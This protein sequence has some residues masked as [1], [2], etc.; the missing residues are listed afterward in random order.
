[1]EDNGIKRAFLTLYFYKK[2]SSPFFA[3]FITIYHNKNLS[4]K[5][6]FTVIITIPYGNKKLFFS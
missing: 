3:G 1:M 6:Y 2:R 4:K 5:L